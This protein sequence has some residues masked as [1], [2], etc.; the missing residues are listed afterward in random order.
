LNIGIIILLSCGYTTVV[1]MG[2]R[3]SRAI[4]LALVV[5]IPLLSSEYV[6]ENGRGFRDA[7]EGSG[8]GLGL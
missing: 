6:R 5:S 8:N 4:A 3:A 7:A 2:I 1:V